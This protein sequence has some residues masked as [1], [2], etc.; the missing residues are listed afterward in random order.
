MSPAI[1]VGAIAQI[2][3]RYYNRNQYQA[4][5]NEKQERKKNQ[6]HKK[7]TLSDFAELEIVL[8]RE[9]YFPGEKVVGLIS[10]KVIK[11]IPFAKKAKLTLHVKGELVYHQG[12]KSDTDKLKKSSSSVISP[13]EVDMVHDHI[14]YN[15]SYILDEGNVGFERGIYSLPFTFSLH[16]RLPVSLRI[17][18]TGFDFVCQYKL[19]TF[20]RREGEEEKLKHTVPLMLA[21]RPPLQ[22][23]NSL[24]SKSESEF[25]R[26]ICC[27]SKST[28]TLQ[29]ELF[30]SSNILKPNETF[31]AFCKLR[32]PNVTLQN[33]FFKKL[34]VKILRLCRIQMGK[35]KKFVQT[36]V[37]RKEIELTQ[38]NTEQTTPET[39][40][41]DIKLEDCKLPSVSTSNK[42][43][44]LVYV[45]T[46][47][48][49]GLQR[50]QRET[51]AKVKNHGYLHLITMKDEELL[52]REVLAQEPDTALL[53]KKSLFSSEPGTAVKLL[54]G[55]E[56]LAEIEQQLREELE[57]E[58]EDTLGVDE[59]TQE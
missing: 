52:N 20:W 47:K 39:L 17:K 35:G 58:D 46:A 30:A 7:K 26:Q 49:A 34:E 38:Q 6:I 16:K 36:P 32:M 1:M 53:L 54:E 31:A 37:F 59:E 5:L 4:K 51:H 28:Q 12:F 11:D 14:F 41:I 55:T 33:L 19:S 50:F 13:E 18:D 29:I 3:R 44:K 40:K 25:T 43:V 45:M 24:V 2:G 56:L 21:Q 27:F 9:T 8:E 42:Y 57:K 10:F 15:H 23:V 48:P 22:V